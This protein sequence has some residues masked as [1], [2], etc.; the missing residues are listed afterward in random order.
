M[1]VS[2]DWSSS[3]WNRKVGSMWRWLQSSQV[4][5]CIG[6]SRLGSMSSQMS[7]QFIMGEDSQYMCKNFKLSVATPTE[8]VPLESAWYTMYPA[9]TY[10]VIIMASRHSLHKKLL[11]PQIHLLVGVY[12]LKWTTLFP[13]R[14]FL[15]QISKD[16]F[17]RFCL[18]FLILTVT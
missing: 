18:I 9:D 3:V 6:N 5:Q 7:Q 12:C 10:A 14:S 1:S 16:I 8:V 4:S 17:L 13:L 11:W 15:L 2:S